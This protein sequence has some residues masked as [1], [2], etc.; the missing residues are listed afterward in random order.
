MVVIRGAYLDNSMFLLF[1]LFFFFRGGEKL[2][3]MFGT[4]KPV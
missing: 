2:V 4:G 1:F 3:L